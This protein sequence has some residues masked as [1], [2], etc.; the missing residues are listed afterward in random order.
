[1]S[2]IR[3]RTVETDLTALAVDGIVNPANSQGVMGGGVAGV[4]RQKGGSEIEAEA[5]KRAPI[6]IGKAVATTAGRLPCRWVI[7]APTMVLPAER[8]NVLSV[9]R[10]THAALECADQKGL[11]SLAFPGM[12]TGVGRVN[13][14]AA[15]QAMVDAIRSF[16]AEN[17]E[18]TLLVSMG[19]ELKNA[20]ENALKTA[21][22]QH[23]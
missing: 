15:A 5:I 22:P 9:K 17:L 4:I 23:G 7:H 11:K 19:P 6:P 13:P 1:M 8:T 2:S 20:F 14:E 10:A 3:I 18:E 12:G 16:K 21:M